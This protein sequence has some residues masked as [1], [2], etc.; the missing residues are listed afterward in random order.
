MTVERRIRAAGF[1]VRPRSVDQ[2][3]PILRPGLKGV[4]VVS[5]GGEQLTLYGYPSVD[6]ATGP[7]GKKATARIR[8]LQRRGQV[9]GN[10]GWILSY[11]TS[12]PQAALTKIDGMLTPTGPSAPVVY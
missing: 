9:G 5:S 7:S 2:V 3:D 11:R 10:G 6:A 8:T 4:L 1:P 12:F